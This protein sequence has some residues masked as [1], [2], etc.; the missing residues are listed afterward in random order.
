MC[1]VDTIAFCF[2]SHRLRPDLW[3]PPLLGGIQI[4]QEIVLDVGHE[5]EADAMK[6]TKKFCSGFKEVLKRHRFFFTYG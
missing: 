4:F 5:N 3:K 6:I 2:T 1:S